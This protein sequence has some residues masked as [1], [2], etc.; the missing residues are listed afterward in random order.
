MSDTSPS[1][2]SSTTPTSQSKQQRGNPVLVGIIFLVLIM[3]GFV[4]AQFA[5]RAGPPFEWRTDFDAALREA[6]QTD[7]R[8]F[9]VLYEPG[10][11]ALG[12]YDRGLFETALVKQRLAQMI[13]VRVAV[14]TVDALRVRYRF[15]GEIMML[16]L[17]PDGDVVGEPGRGPNLDELWFKTYVFPSHDR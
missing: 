3:I 10:A 2:A 16:V 8:I 5:E 12:R 9:L 4:A 7:Q 15:D 13:P 6:R 14:P 11:T 17:K 1:P